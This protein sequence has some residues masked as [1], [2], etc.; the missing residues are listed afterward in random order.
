MVMMKSLEKGHDKIKK[1]CTILRD[2]TLEPAQKEAEEIIKQ[3]QNKAESIIA[4]G[5]SAAE[6][7]LAEARAEIE[8]ERNVFQSSLTQ[9]SKQ[10]LEFLRQSI[11][12]KFFSES[13]PK[14]IEKNAADPQLVAKLITAII[15]AL[16]KEGLA[17][18]LT[19]LIPKTI[20]PRQINE[21][22]LEEIL[23][24]LKNHSVS[25]GKNGAGVLV[26]LED[27]KMTIDI[28]EDSLKELMANYVVRKDFRKMFFEE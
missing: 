4:E 28:S 15:H 14:V 18:D 8:R 19:T 24:T 25:L 11:E 17:A 21:L 23:K 10:S 26:K 7:L 13:L 1:I 9:A 22:L 5:Q 6:K 27:R 20:T 3:A 16:E 2:E 12:T